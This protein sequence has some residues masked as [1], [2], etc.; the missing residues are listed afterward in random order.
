MLPRLLLLALS[1]SLCACAST[2]PQPVP[3]EIPPPP[4]ALFQPCQTP[5]DLPDVAT[6]K[7][8]VVALIQALQWG[9]CERARSIGLMEAWPR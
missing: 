1:L 8:L 6:A 3:A 9:G 5:D 2:P 4:A 7:D